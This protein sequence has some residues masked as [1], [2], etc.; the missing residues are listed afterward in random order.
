MIDS[1]DIELVSNHLWCLNG[2]YA[3]TKIRQDGKLSS[4]KMHRLIMNATTGL[5]VDH[6]NGIPLDNRKSNLRLCTRA[7][8]SRYVGKTQKPT[9]S[10]YKGVTL[11]R[12]GKW[13]AQIQRT[14][15]GVKNRY[16]FGEFATEEEAAKAYDK[17]ATTLFGEYAKTNF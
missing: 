13:K 5:D 7:E 14:T 11:L 3:H 15:E 16:S 8:N 4:V 17:A 1:E 6:K 2:L 9:S 12:N 10:Q